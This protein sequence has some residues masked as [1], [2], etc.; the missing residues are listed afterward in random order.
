MDER[1]WF[2]H[3]DPGVP[4]SIAYAEIPIPSMLARAAARAP[5]ATAISFLGRRISYR[6]LK[7]E[8]DRLAAAILG[9]G[10]GKGA[11]VAIQMPNLPQTVIAY[12]A[13]LTAGAEV[14]LTN[15]LYTP[16]EIEHQWNDAECVLAVT[17]DFLWTQRV[18]ELRG[19]VGV[20]S[21]VIA[22]I[23]EVLRFPVNLLARRKL[24]RQSP[25][26]IAAVRPEPGVHRFRELVRAAPPGPPAVAIGFDD[27]A[28]LQYTG[29]TTGVA[30]AAVLT[31]RNLSCNV[32]Q[33][34]AWMSG[35]AGDGEVV[36]VALPLFHVFG[37][38]AAMNFAV[39]GAAEMVLV[40]NPRDTAAIARA[41]EKRRVTLFPGVPA[42]YNALT[43]LPGIERRDLSS[44][45]ACFS[46]S[47]PMPPDV[48]ERFERLTGARIL[49]GFGLSETSPVTHLNPLGGP[50]KVGSIGIPFPDT[51]ARIVDVDDPSRELGPGKEGE[52]LLRGPQ[53]MREYWRQPEET[54]FALRDGWL[55]TGDLAAM[56]EDG[57]FRIVGRKKDMINCSGLKVFP[58]EVDAVLAA[59]DDVLE[60]ATIGVPDPARGETVKSFVVLRPGRSVR[61]ADLETFCRGRLAAYKV[62]RE[63][64]F[65]PELPKSTVLKVLRRAL[66]E[67]EM[68]RRAAGGGPPA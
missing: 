6:E 35:L 13:A 42:M 34:A 4:R 26:A 51:D 64:E 68:A 55:A 27:I 20:Q 32:Q 40:P 66:R 9:L 58:D 57:Y 31:H 30:K 10:V 56:D 43:N 28:V 63:I 37:M 46:G 50:R 14:V 36:L 21:F 5:G 16:R 44:L 45:K 48:L 33:Q 15:P 59:H 24:A 67:R 25:P 47:A 49:E 41:I 60:A 52:L 53:V 29:G 65:L 8:V 38:T 54:R 18:R 39:L 7:R 3:Y 12:Y 1:P 23:P 17:T 11:R 22:S 61:A 2:A 19:K 62:P